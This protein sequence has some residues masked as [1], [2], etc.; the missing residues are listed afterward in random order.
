MNFTITEDHLRR[1]CEINSF[2]V[3]VNGM[4]LFGFRGCTPTNEDNH[5]FRK[6]HQLVLADN[7]R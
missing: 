3:F 1:L 4:G 7:P 2:E 5:E 6:E